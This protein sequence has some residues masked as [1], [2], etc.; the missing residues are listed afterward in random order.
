MGDL[1]DRWLSP[2]NEIPKLAVYGDRF[3]VYGYCLP[4]E[5]RLLSRL[6]AARKH[7]WPETEW[8]VR[9]LREAVEAWDGL[10]DRSLF[11]VLREVTGGLLA[12]EELV[13]AIGDMPNWLAEMGQGN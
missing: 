12:D 2:D 13:K 5:G 1:F 9:R 11:V 8:F 6:T 7:Q 3:E 4:D 10:V